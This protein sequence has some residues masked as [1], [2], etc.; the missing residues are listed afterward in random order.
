MAKAKGTDDLFD[1]MRA[2]GLRKRAARVLS[3][4]AGAG[5]G[6]SSASQAQAK[7]MIKDLR[8]LA[9]ELEDR[10]TGKRA[11]RTAA[12]KKAAATR[13]RKAKARS[14]AAKKA[15]ATRRSSRSSRATAKR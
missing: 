9:D 14:T 8:G 5:R 13:A 10:V 15:A 4:A 6:A 11:N 2:R 3:D 12:A 1:L 7:K